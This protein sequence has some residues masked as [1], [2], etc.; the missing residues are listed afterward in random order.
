MAVSTYAADKL[1][2]GLRDDIDAINPADALKSY[3]YDG[4]R[5]RFQFG[6]GLW[7]DWINLAINWTTQDW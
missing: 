6:N 2:A 7:G 1:L 5:I 4:A 3:E